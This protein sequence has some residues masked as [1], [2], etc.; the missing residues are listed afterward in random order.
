MAQDICIEAKPSFLSRHKVKFAVVAALLLIGLG[1]VGLSSAF[2]IHH[3]DIPNSYWT[4]TSVLK[5][6]LLDT[7][8]FIGALTMITITTLALVIWGYWKL[9]SLPKKHSAHTGQPKLVFWL[10][11]LGFFYGWLWI[12]AIIIVVI[13]WE[14]LSNAI[15]RLTR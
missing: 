2:V 14:K 5:P 13:D 3:T 11:M 4:T 6:K 7:P 15:R 1:S 9:H 10:C 12:A 8:V